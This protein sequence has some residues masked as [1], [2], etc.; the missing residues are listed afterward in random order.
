[1]FSCNKSL[2]F[3]VPQFQN[4]N[5]LCSSSFILLLFC[6]LDFKRPTPTLPP[7]SDLVPVFPCKI[8]MLTSYLPKSATE[9]KCSKSERCLCLYF[10]PVPLVVFVVI[11]LIFSHGSSIDFEHESNLLTGKTHTFTSDRQK[12][13][14][15]GICLCVGSTLLFNRFTWSIQHCTVINVLYMFFSWNRRRATCVNFPS[16]F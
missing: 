8:S 1:M 4:F 15:F 2:Y 13:L 6:S 7:R 10:F 9:P 14:W 12:F 5:F 11:Y 3:P 16:D